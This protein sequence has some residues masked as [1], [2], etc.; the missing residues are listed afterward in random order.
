MGKPVEKGKG[1]PRVIV[2][3]PGKEHLRSVLLSR[4]FGTAA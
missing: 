4:V 2:K 3:T 1:R